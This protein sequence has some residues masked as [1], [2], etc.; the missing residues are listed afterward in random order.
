MDA[1]LG[2]EP[3][4][5]VSKTADLPL[6][7]DAILKVSIPCEQVRAELQL[8]YSVYTTDGR[9]MPLNAKLPS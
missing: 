3:R 8:K 9:T 2:I 6:V 1:S 5:A 4:R 7:N